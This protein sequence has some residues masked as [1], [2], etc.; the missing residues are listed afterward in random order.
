MT[1]TEFRVRKP[2][3]RGTQKQSMKDVRTD[4]RTYDGQSDPMWRHFDPVTG[5]PRHEQSEVVKTTYC[6]FLY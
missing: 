2:V 1:D 5:H 3:F 4:G 6:K